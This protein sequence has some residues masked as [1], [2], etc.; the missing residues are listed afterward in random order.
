MI[1]LVTEYEAVYNSLLEI[2]TSDYLKYTVI[3]Y[4]KSYG[5]KYPF[6]EFYLQKSD[7]ENVTAVFLRYNSFLYCAIDHN[8]DVEEI[9]AWIGGM[10]DVT[11]YSGIPLSLENSETCF[12][13]GKTGESMPSKN[14]AF[15]LDSSNFKEIAELINSDRDASVKD[16]F[17]LDISHLFRHGNLEVFGIFAD[18]KLASFAAFSKGEKF[19]VIPFVFTHEYFRGKGFS[20]NVLSAM[21]CEKNKEYR[22]L[23]S[24][25]NLKFYEKCGFEL[26]QSCFKYYL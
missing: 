15:P 25:E 3:M 19:S 23:C 18:E 8:A 26:I 6:A 10:T 13:M 21:C 1:S 17:Y 4:L 12:E 5:A 14:T 22:L 9:S 7:S 24:E 2:K 11:V 20:K 16:E